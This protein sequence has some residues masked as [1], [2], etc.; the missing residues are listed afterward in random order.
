MPQ[1]HIC[2]EPTEEVCSFSLAGGSAGA[3]VC[4]TVTAVLSPDEEAKKQPVDLEFGGDQSDSED[5]RERKEDEENKLDN[6]IEFNA[7]GKAELAANKPS[8][9]LVAGCDHS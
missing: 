1:L 5:E 3:A 9:L 7:A 8:T 6:C 4:Y 2:A